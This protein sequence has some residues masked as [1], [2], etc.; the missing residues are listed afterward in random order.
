[1][2]YLRTDKWGWMGTMFHGCVSRLF[3]SEVRSRSGFGVRETHL[4]QIEVNCVPK[5]GTLG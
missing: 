5:V 3:Q 4:I 2:I 1:M